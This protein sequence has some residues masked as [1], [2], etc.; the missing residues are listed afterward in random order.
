MLR[1]LPSVIMATTALVAAEPAK[2][3]FNLSAESAEKSLKRFGEQSGME[4]LFPTA[5]VKGVRTRAVKGE[6]TAR[7]ALDAMLGGIPLVAIVDDKTG[8][9][10][11]KPAG[12][13]DP[14]AAPAPA[15]AHLRDSEKKS[16]PR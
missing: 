1:M 6:M 13:D 5:T 11:I 2:I 8:S 7:A 12:P 16:K 10:T 3:T 4:V 14:R 15:G 9:V